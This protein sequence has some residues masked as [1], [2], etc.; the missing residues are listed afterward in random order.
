M[1]ARALTLPTVIDNR[2][3]TVEC[4]KLTSTPK[5]ERQLI[6]LE[7]LASAAEETA[8]WTHDDTKELVLITV[9]TLLLFVSTTIDALKDR[10]IMGKMLKIIGRRKPTDSDS[11]EK[12]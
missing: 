2:S 11:S 4:A 12:K 7:I 10:K 6:M 8:S 1:K 9:P 3:I 5:V